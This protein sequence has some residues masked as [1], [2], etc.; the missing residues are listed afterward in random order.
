MNS[1]ELRVR[2]GIDIG[3]TKTEIAAID[4]S[5]AVVGTARGASGWGVTDVVEKAAALVRELS[6]RVGSPLTI[7]VG[8]PGQVS[9][10]RQTVAH[11]VNLGIEGANIG[12]ELERL[13]GAPVTVENDVKAAALAAH[14]LVATSGT[15]A[16]LNFGTGV[17]SGIVTP[18]GVWRGDTGLAGEVGHLTFDANGPECGCGQL[19]CIEAYAGGGMLAKRWGRTSDHPVLD[20]FDA[21]DAGDELAIELRD[22]CIAAIAAA[23]RTVVMM[24]DPKQIVLGGGLTALGARLLGPVQELL[25]Q[26]SSRSPFLSATGVA[27]RLS[28]VTPGYPVGAVGAALLGAIEMEHS[29]G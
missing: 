23:S 6:D 2:F 17:A 29:I 1:S 5:G 28:L 26:Q 8:V 20:I 27:E 25:R 19:G 24:Y 15:V 7:G 3:G 12:L 14:R 18:H 9:S 22:G 13:T 4:E 21:A 16:Y 11:I 10:D